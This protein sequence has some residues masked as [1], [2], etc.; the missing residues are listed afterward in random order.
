MEQQAW[1][2]TWS[3]MMT[4]KAVYIAV[5]MGAGGMM[6]KVMHGSHER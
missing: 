5:G 3:A 6:V 4:S 1:R 2:C